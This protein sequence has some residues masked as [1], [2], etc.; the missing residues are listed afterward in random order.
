[1]IDIMKR[2]C[3]QVLLAV[4]TLVLAGNA[5]G[6]STTAAPGS[7][8]DAIRGVLTAF[9]EAWN[10]HDA[11]AFSM[12]FAQ[13]ADFTNVAGRTA[14]GRKE[15]EAFHAPRFAEQFKESSQK[16]VGSA[17]R[18]IRPDVAVVD[19]RWEMTGARSSDGHDIPLRKGLLSFV[20][21]KDGDTWLITVM[22]NMNLID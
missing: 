7:D 12:V 22:H 2:Q 19:A 17:I 10:K 6:G 21:T 3:A 14:R 13:D 20:M 16:I 9:V 4:S 11:K 18:L 5:L 1:M 8:E 15:V